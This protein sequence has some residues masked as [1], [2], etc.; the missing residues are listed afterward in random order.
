MQ[1]TDMPKQLWDYGIVWVCK[2][3][4]QM[5]SLSYRSNCRTPMEIITGDTPDMSEYL[6]VGL[7]DWVLY[8]NN[9]G[10]SETKLGRML[11]ISHRVGPMM[12]YWILP[13]SCHVI[14]CTTVQRLTLL[15]QQQ[16]LYKE[17][18]QHFD[19]TVKEKLRDSNHIILLN[20]DEQ[21]HDWE[22]F[23]FSQDKDFLCEYGKKLALDDPTIPEA[24]SLHMSIPD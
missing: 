17:R 4:Q 19:I 18:C 3:M 16:N 23:D 8:K 12:S 6:D 22:N 13:I 20:N 1:A 11:G 9:A 21:P 2:L 7:Y 15:D 24:D 10:Y 5:T 14:S